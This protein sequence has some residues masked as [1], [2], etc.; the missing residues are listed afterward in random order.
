MCVFGGGTDISALHKGMLLKE[1]KSM[2]ITSG[3][4]VISALRNV[5][6]LRIRNQCLLQVKC[7]TD[8][9]FNQNCKT[10]CAC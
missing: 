2:P 5:Y 7:E 10:Q 3:G 6:F 4:T 9:S 1:T 8:V